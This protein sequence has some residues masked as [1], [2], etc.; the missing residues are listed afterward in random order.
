MM[1]QST[2]PKKQINET[3]TGYAT[4][5]YEQVPQVSNE[6]VFYTTPLPVKQEK[7]GET[8]VFNFAKGSTPVVNIYQK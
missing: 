6:Q 2:I 4:D 8:F 1:N 7:K 5:Y 3:G